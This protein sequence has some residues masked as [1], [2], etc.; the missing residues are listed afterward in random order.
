MSGTLQ[1]LLTQRRANEHPVA[2]PCHNV[3]Y[4]CICCNLG[5]FYNK[6]AQE[7][8]GCT[9]LLAIFLENYM[10]IKCNGDLV[11]NIR[12]LC[13]NISRERSFDDIDMKRVEE[14]LWTNS[15]VC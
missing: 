11:L 7:L 12:K 15:Q 8:H 2:C 9:E 1:K 6:S 4:S 10:L 5:P 14:C 13:A 3:Q